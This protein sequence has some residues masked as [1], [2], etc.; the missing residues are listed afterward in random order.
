M[1]EQRQ[2]AILTLVATRPIHS[3]EELA[4]LLEAQGIPAT[5]AT[6]SRDIKELGLVRV[7]LKG[8][9]ETDG[10]FKYIVPSP[11][12]TYVSRLHRVVAE[13]A[14]NVEAAGNLIVVKT[15]PGSANLVAYA[16]DEANW[17]ELLGTLAGDDTIFAVVRDAGETSMVRQRL[18]D[19]MGSKSE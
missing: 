18:L 16:L 15:P 19:L 2:R 14:V 9:A 12:A 10:L 7:P 1:K 3:Q 4:A 8:P 17:P 6:V 5:Q 13:L 11:V